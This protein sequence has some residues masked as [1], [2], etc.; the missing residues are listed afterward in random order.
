MSG[1]PAAPA[2]VRHRAGTAGLGPP[3]STPA[4]RARSGQPKQRKAFLVYWAVCF[5]T[6]VTWLFAV[7]AA[8]DDAWLQFEGYPLLKLGERCEFSASFCDYYKTG[9]A[10]QFFAAI[11][12]SAT[13]VVMIVAAFKPAPATGRLGA[14]AGTML[15]VFSVLQL[16][17]FSIMAASARRREHA[18]MHEK[19]G[20]SVAQYSSRILVSTCS[21]VASS[22]SHTR[23]LNFV[24]IL[25]AMPCSF[26]PCASW[27]NS[28]GHSLFISDPCSRLHLLLDNARVR[29]KRKCCPSL[30]L[31]SLN[32]PPPPALPKVN[33]YWYGI[34]KYTKVSHW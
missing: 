24:A 33:A 3:P 34:K 31:V 15:L 5:A 19:M 12:I 16:A 8:S 6:A 17:A 32:A 14:A 7:A 1:A 21:L 18:S 30:P 27:R 26:T 4:S 25:C 28:N 13:V 22:T 29:P 20:C 10:F 11:V 23:G 2:G 9:T